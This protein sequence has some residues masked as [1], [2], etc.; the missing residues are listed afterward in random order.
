MIR[1]QTIKRAQ[2]ERAFC[3]G[4]CCALLLV[5]FCAATSKAQESDDKITVETTDVQLNVG[6]V[7]RQGNTVKYLSRGD[8]SVYEDGVKRP[9]THFEPTEAPF[10]LVMLLDVSGSTVTFRQQLKLAAFRF[11]DALAPEDR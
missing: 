8:F 11:L 10:S 1:M 3:L 4:L 6:V 5:F 7:D 9:I 2:S